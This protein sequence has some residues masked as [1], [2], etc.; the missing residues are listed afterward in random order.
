MQGVWKSIMQFIKDR[1]LELYI[2]YIF[3]MEGFKDK[4]KKGRY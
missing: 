4:L 3:W 2:V 1:I